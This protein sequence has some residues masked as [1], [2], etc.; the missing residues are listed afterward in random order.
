MLFR[1]PAPLAANVVTV[2]VTVYVFLGAHSAQVDLMLA[3]HVR[4]LLETG[5]YFII[6]IDLD[7]TNN[8]N[9]AVKYSTST[10]LCM[11]LFFSN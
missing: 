8:Q 11:E 5:D 2:Y 7:Y 3:L 10:L 9:G 1:A 4:G 6:S